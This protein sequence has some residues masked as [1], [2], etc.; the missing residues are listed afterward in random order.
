LATSDAVDSLPPELIRRFSYGCWYFALPTAEERAT[1][2]RL[3]RQKYGLADADPLPP[4][5]QWTGAEIA[6][7]ASLSWEL[8]IPLCEAAH[9]I[10]PLA[11]SAKDS[12]AKLEDQ[13]HQTFLCASKGKVYSKDSPDRSLSLTAKRKIGLAS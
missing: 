5:E 13:A 3:Y 11:V 10:V 4:D 7:C 9:Y 2:W 1:I 12:L 6:R 8:D